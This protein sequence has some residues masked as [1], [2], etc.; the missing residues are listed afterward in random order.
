[1]TKSVNE[2]AYVDALLQ[3]VAETEKAIKDG[4]VTIYKT[5]EELFTAW[6]QEDKE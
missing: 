4:T 5:P 6:E 2:S 1:M 3:D